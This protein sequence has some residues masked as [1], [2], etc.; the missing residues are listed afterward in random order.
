MAKSDA[1]FEYQGEVLTMISVSLVYCCT[2][3]VASLSLL[4]LQLLVIRI[5]LIMIWDSCV[6]LLLASMI[7]VESSF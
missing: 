2:W 6:R 1:R 7:D 5:T 3:S 4:T